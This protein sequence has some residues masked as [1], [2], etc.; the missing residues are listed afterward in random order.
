VYLE[1]HFHQVLNDLL[2][3]A[4]IRHVLHRH[5]HKNTLL[6]AAGR[7]TLDFRPQNYFGFTLV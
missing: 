1:S 7:L 3:L 4:F 6:P 5:D 2:N